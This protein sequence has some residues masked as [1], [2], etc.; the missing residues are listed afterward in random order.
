MLREVAPV[1]LDVLKPIALAAF[2]SIL[3]IAFVRFGLFMLYP[4]PW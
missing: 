4:E 2:V 1:W 3:L